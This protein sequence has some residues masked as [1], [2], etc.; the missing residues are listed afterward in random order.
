[1]A[2]PAAPAQ[3]LCIRKSGNGSVNH[4]EEFVVLLLDNPGFLLS[5]I[6][7]LLSFCASAVSFACRCM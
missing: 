7:D 5:A 4:R 3:N 1:M 2:R 6:L